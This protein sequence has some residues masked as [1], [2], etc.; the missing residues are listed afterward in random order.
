MHELADLVCLG[1][2]FFFGEGK[3]W[4][5]VELIDNL[6]PNCMELLCSI[7]TWEWEVVAT[8]VARGILFVKSCFAMKGLM[9]VSNVVYEQSHGLG[10][11]VFLGMSR[12]TVLGHDGINGGLV[13]AWLSI[14]PVDNG[15]YCLGNVVFW[16][17][18]VE[19]RGLA[20]LVEVGLVI[21][22]PC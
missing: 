2:P 14:E 18:V 7:V 8:S 22:V 21:K 5:S 17:G 6:V 9:G 4:V 12:R 10:P 15:A 1:V 16:L 13:K 19:V 20:T 11:G 3:F